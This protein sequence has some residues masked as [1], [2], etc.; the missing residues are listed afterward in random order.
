MR[1][2]YCVGLS[3]PGLLLMRRVVGARSANPVYRGAHDQRQF[4]AKHEYRFDNSVPNRLFEQ[5]RLSISS[6]NP[7]PRRGREGEIEEHIA[8]KWHVIA[9]QEAI[10][11]L[12]HECLTNHC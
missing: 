2:V 4:S 9:L 11:Y 3:D 6:C 12:Q 1:W 10:E 8:V 5:I 7:G